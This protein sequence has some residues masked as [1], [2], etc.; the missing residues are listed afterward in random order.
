MQTFLP[1]PDFQKSAQVLDYK[2]LG[3][4]R[5]EAM[6]IYKLIAGE[7][8][9]SAWKNHPATL[10]WTGYKDALAMYYNTIRCEWINRGYKNTMPEL[11][12]DNKT[13]EMPHW[14]GDNKFHM[15]HRANLLRKDPTYYSKFNWTESSDL[16]YY[17][18]K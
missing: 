1:L 2:R 16:C 14:F 4:Q 5:L 8:K 9:S 10:M 11:T 15:S 13:P 7:A 3:K 12:V 6:W 18:P 17:W